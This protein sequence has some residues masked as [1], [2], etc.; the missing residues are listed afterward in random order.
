MTIKNLK[1]LILEMPEIPGVYQF[2]DQNEKALYIGK[3]KNLKKR[4]K[5]YLDEKRLV[6]RIIRMLSLA[7]KIE[8]IPT[9][10]E[11]EALLLEC[12]LIKKLMPRYNILLRDDKSFPYILISDDEFGRIGKH[13]GKRSEN[14][15]YFGP[16]ASGF[17]V[18][19][20]LDILK[21]SFLL[22]SCSNSEFK[23]RKKPCLEYQ[24]KRCSAPC[25]ALIDKKDY[26]IL[27]LEALDFLKGKS[28]KVQEELIKQMNDYSAKTEY[29]KAAIIRNRIKALS[30]IQSKQNINLL[31]LNDADVISLAKQNNLACLYISFYR[32]GHN[33]GSKPYF[34]NIE[35][36][37][38][39]EK[40]IAAFLGQFYLNQEIPDNII[41]S[42]KAS[43]SENIE[44]FLNQ[45]S[46]KNSTITIP[47]AGYKFNL[48]QDHLL[49]AKKFLEQKIG[50]Q[51]NDQKMLL[52]LKILFDLPKIPERIEVYDNSH[53][54]GEYMVSA[55]ICAG[56]EGFMKN[57]YRKYNIRK[58]DLVHQDDTAILKQAL[59]RRFQRLKTEG[60]RPDLI[61]IDGG[62]GQL[63]A[64]LEVFKQLEIIDQNIVCMS[65][66]P[67][68][69][70]GE[71]YFH[72]PGKESFQLEKGIPLAFYLQRLRDEAH[73][74]AIGTH[75]NKR[76]KSITKSEL[77]EIN[78]IG[79]TR[80]MILLNHFGSVKAIKEASLADIERINGIG[81]N[82]A[83]K[84]KNYFDK[85]R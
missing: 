21:K 10:T 63:S 71:E 75:R 69:N 43:E 60:I 64:A 33:Y 9:S 59:T 25:V 77:D 53:I 23:N 32:S 66:G 28:V 54:S 73:R 19:K 81:K 46:G 18:N 12:N 22:R 35:E 31:S 20:T 6:P 82:I 29:E 27:V 41:L 3:A 14:G 34:M 7:D 26:D 17:D 36:D 83:R 55:M 48:I 49:N 16:F 72:L 52:E 37:D 62:K 68:R 11:T 67:N 45:L 44:K 42:H 70:A 8:T 15:N 40:I 85:S 13:Y 76:A 39:E 65:K 4:L 58:S 47:K 78:D 74:F 24:I 56:P 5:N 50:S 51:I 84:I 80:K 79:K 30:A 2:F 1:D 61:I 38:N 57:N